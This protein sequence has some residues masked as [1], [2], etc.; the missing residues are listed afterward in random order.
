MND[1][2]LDAVRSWAEIGTPF[3]LAT[4]VGV[5]GST[6]RG[7]AAR[8]L[9]GLDG[10][11]VGTVSGGCLDADLRRVAV[12]VIE[13][14]VAE[15]VEFDLTADDEAIWGWGVGCNGATDLL[16]EPA[17]SA[18]ALVDLIGQHSRE[19]FCLVHPVDRPAGRFIVTPGDAGDDPVTRAAREAIDVGRHRAVTVADSPH[20]FEVIG[21]PPRLVVFGAGHDAAPVVA[22]AARLGF[23]T[24]VV[25]DRRQFLTSERFP[26]AHELVHAVPG[27]L[28][29]AVRPDSKTAV[30]LMSHN[31][32]RDLDALESLLGTDAAY[33]GALGPGER[34]ER[35]LADLAARGCTVTGHDLDRLYGPAG[36]DIGAEG[37][38]E[39]AWSVMS[40]VLS[41]M[42]GK[43]GGPLRLRKGPAALRA[44]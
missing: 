35:M 36:L 11:S 9:V 37:P 13:S 20:L 43:T 38:V 44:D 19:S 27:E 8:Q 7:L 3:A 2:V 21:A 16:V 42:R 39:I 4:V 25:D 22:Q 31:Y 24:V 40:E 14:G 29:R 6:Y 17:E 12:R 1:P 26:E 41:V 18:L 34:L 33:I 32:L 5:R 10:T 23:R 28:S 15:R 30:I